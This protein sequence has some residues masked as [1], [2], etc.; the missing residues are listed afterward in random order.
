MGEDRQP[1][2]PDPELEPWLRAAYQETSPSPE[3]LARIEGRVVR[4]RERAAPPLFV[5]WVLGVGF[6]GAVSAALLFVWGPQ[7]APES[8]PIASG[9]R[10]PP[11]ADA[12]KPVPADLAP[13][14]P[15][16]SLSDA[17]EPGPR[18][19]EAPP[20]TSIVEPGS[21]PEGRAEVVAGPLDVE[22]I[23]QQ[24]ANLVAAI[25]QCRANEEPLT[26]QVAVD[27]DGVPVDVELQT[28]QADPDCVQAVFA[29]MRFELEVGAPVAG[30]PEGPVARFK[31]TVDARP[32]GDDP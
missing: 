25:D 22:A 24:T 16:E 17:E 32:P 18:F 14:K 9:Q 21:T 28:G 3:M 2:P 6:A 12:S 10:R 26:V 11:P 30:D 29:S 7:S 23:T 5:Q 20:P 19:A 4:A 13:P 27:A 31:V 15:P 1:E 8:Q